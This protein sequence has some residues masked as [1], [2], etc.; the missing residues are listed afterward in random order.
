MMDASV[1]RS[2]YSYFLIFDIGFSYY[3]LFK[4]TP[5]LSAISFLLLGAPKK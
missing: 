1:N 4:S 2:G 5:L 3:Y